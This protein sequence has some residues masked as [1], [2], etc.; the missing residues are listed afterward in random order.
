MGP[1]NHPGQDAQPAGQVGA[2]EPQSK[3]AL[4][5]VNCVG[6]AENPLRLLTVEVKATLKLG[7]LFLFYYKF[8]FLLIC[9]CFGFPS[10]SSRNYSQ[11][12]SGDAAVLGGL[13]PGLLRA[14]V[15][16]SR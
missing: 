13:N 3:G 15:C 10:G 4:S 16:A 12:C 6:L 9:F 1:G 5:A 11:L 14:P 8:L 7:L 2:L